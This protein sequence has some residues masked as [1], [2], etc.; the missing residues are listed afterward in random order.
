MFK[1][2]ALLSTLALLGNAAAQETKASIRLLAFSRAGE[3]LEAV[4][5]DGEGKPLLD[6]PLAL[7]TEQLS[8]AKSVTVRSLVFRSP[9]DATK[10]LGKVVLPAGDE[11]I[12]VF[13]P[14]PAGGTA[15][16][17]INAVEM[18][19]KSFG[20]GDYAFLNYSGTR[21]GCV[22]DGTKLVVPQGKAGVYQTSKSGKGAGNRPIL[23]YQ[24]K[25]G[26]WEDRPFFSSRIIIQDGV[27][28]LILVCLHPVTKTIDFRG[29]ADFVS[30]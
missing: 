3:D 8:S 6:Q 21:I 19:S 15:V 20:S 23:C 4:V 24:E 12:L 2:A 13:L 14:L 11:F 18:P 22:I 7:P 28:N 16:Y 27:R 25:D 5:T 26:K 30:P 1:L 17:Q 10:V 9:K 29:I